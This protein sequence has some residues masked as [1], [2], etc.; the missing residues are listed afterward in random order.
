MYICFLQEI[1]MENTKATIHDIAR[2]LGIDS[3]TVSRA[4][5]NSS[6][7]TQ[8]TKDKIMAK[9]LELGYQRNHLASSLRK[10]K[11]YTLGVIVPRIS[12]HF[13]SS[14]ISGIEETAHE[15]GYNVIICQSLEQL[16]RE[17]KIVETLV[18]NRI[19]GLLMSISME[20]VN[21]DHLQ[22]LKRR[23]IPF[24]F[25]DRHCEIPG[26]SNVIIDDFQA[27]F[28]ATEHLILNRSRKIVHFAGP[29]NLEIYKNRFKGYK[30]ALKKYQIP[31]IEEFVLT[32]RLMKSDG[33][34]NAKKLL[35]LPYK[36]DAFFSANDEA[37][38]S[39]MQ[40]LKEKGVKM[41]EDIAVVGFSNESISS[42]IEP[43]LTTI[44]QS[45]FEIGKTATSLLLSQIDKEHRGQ[46]SETIMLK[47]SLIKRKSSIR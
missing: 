45:G 2:I 22:G 11:T 28:D 12:R 4:L 41:P 24:V 29:Q 26:N 42:V 19:D 6:R 46:M 17:Q 27:G 16:A 20:T 36:I 7:V 38:I 14:A 5:N 39:A 9:A 15:A 47:P 18:A 30:A 37:A 35:A 21:Y 3:S 33:I 25:F 13:F 8:K 34:E 40:Y 43:P 44:N 31:Y 10:S 32:S 1:G 23:K